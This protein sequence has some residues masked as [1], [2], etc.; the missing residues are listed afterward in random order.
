M[1]TTDQVS[2]VK[3]GHR[4]SPATAVAWTL[5]AVAA[6]VI[7]RPDRALPFDTVDF[8]EFLPIL[9]AYASFWERTG[10]LVDYYAGQ[11][12][13]NLLPYVLL[14]AKWEVF[15]WWSPGWQWSRY[16]VMVT[17]T[18]LAF[19]LLRRLGA[20]ALGA[21]GGA[22]VFLVAPAAT[23]GW[24]RLTSAEPLGTLLVL[25]LCLVILPARRLS[26][27]RT[28]WVVVALLTIGI[29]FTKEMLAAA[30]ALPGG[31]L[32]LTDQDGHLRTPGW[33]RHVTQFGILA[34]VIGVLCIGP[35]L[36]V[37]QAASSSSYASLYGMSMR[38]I[39]S[40]LATWMSTF[41]PVDPKFGFP[42][43]AMRIANLVLVASL[44]T[45]WYL[46]LRDSGQEKWWL[47]TFALLFPLIGAVAYAPWPAYQTFYAI[48]FLFGASVMIAFAL[49]GF[50]CARRWWVRVAA[51]G[52]WGLLMLVAC[53][54]AH[55]QAG[56]AGASQL[57]T[58]R[59]VQRIST[60]PHVDSVHVATGFL[61]PQ[62]WQGAAKTLSRYAS[63]LNLRW[64]PS[65]DV[66]CT[67]GDGVPPI[68]RQ[69][70]IVVVYRDVLC[71]HLG[72]AEPVVQRYPRL[73]L[74]RLQVVLDSVRIDI[75]VP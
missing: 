13:A 22:S 68:D 42:G 25:A 48:P 29:V 7:Y 64:P 45:G 51:F 58:Y 70:S 26:E 21:F 16:A 47:F 39:T 61:A 63:A 6:F 60:M 44:A 74:R 10:A 23:S 66:P 41:V 24:I 27:S 14:S 73:S 57:A 56:L 62:K 12:R 35:M 28:R 43:A 9:Q 37:A 71:A 69:G 49:T 11:G 53:V 17:V 33:S 55:R 4:L 1:L 34:A 67:D 19:H 32:L 72:N 54:D 40:T 5:A 36:V 75:G 31:L 46:H 2:S 38:P 20:S 8:S 3:H 15:E 59:L 65:R 50:Q 52:W 30:M 18:I